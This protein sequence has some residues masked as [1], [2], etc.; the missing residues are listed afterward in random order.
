ME[1]TVYV[2]KYF[3]MERKVACNNRKTFNMETKEEHFNEK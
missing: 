3:E 2:E 1:I